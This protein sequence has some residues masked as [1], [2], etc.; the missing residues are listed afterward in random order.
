MKQIRGV[1]LNGVSTYHLLDHLGIVSIIMGI[2]YL[3]HEEAQFQLAKKYYPTIHAEL[4]DTESITPNFLFQN[5]DALFISEYYASGNIAKYFKP[6]EEIYEKKMR[7]VHCPHGFSD[8]SYYLKLCAYE[9]ITLIY[10]QHML[11]MLKE[12]DVLQFLKSHVITGNYRF[13]YFKMHQ[14]FYQ[15]II[16]DEVLS[17]FKKQQPL[18]LYAPTWGDEEQSTTILE[19]AHH[20]IGTLPD[21]YNLVVKLHPMFETREIAFLYQMMALYEDKPNVKFLTNFPLVYPLLANTEIYIGDASAIGYDYLTFNKPMFFMSKDS[22]QKK[23]ALYQCGIEVTVKDYPNL[24]PLIEKGLNQETRLSEVRSKMY[25]YTFGQEIPFE[26]I[27]NAI[28]EV[29]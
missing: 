22:Q 11:D 13:T 28:V 18:I 4:G 29:L 12:C 1:A 26:K 8:K 25:D 19:A 20:V 10:G 3:M 17:H 9:D 5:F 14:Q 23:P 24:Y 7:V 15:K 6:L 16:E 21:H 2:P 27:R